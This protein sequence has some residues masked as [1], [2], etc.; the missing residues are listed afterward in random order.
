MNEGRKIRGKEYAL[1]L[2]C[3]LFRKINF[4]RWLSK[5]RARDRVQKA[6]KRVIQ[7]K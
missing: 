3:A 1:L 4:L 5:F 7:F 6:V 2:R